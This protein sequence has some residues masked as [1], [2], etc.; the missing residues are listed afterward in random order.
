ML[1]K[2]MIFV[3]SLAGGGAERTIVNII[4]HINKKKYQVVLV[5]IK[6]VK[7]DH[8]KSKYLKLI[9]GECKII[10]LDTT[11]SKIYFFDIVFKLAKCIREEKPNILFSTI[12]KANIITFLGKVLSRY[13]V[14][15][16]L[17]ESNNRTAEG[18]SVIHKKA[19]SY[20]YNRA[21]KIISLSKGVA[22]DLINNFNINSKLINVIYNPID[23]KEIRR[24]SLQTKHLNLKSG[25][26]KLII[27]IGRLSE[28]KDFP[29]L[30][31]AFKIVSEDMNIKLLILGQGPLYGELYELTKE[32]KI[33]DKI[34]FLGFK[35]NP[36]PYIKQSDLFVLSSKFEG[37]GHVITES[38]A[39]DTP[40]I[41]SNCKSGPSEIIQDNISGDLFDVGNVNML[42]N[43]I[44]TLLED[45]NLKANYISAASRRVQD[46]EVESIIKEYENVF[47]QL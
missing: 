37:F 40:V 26:E 25:S 22:E 1:K 8:Q 15:I 7:K 43:K 27:S 46:F 21:S 13:K 9:E 47:D 41:S 6:N 2:L 39:L 10:Y 18:I 29:T 28:Q 20:I 4:K 30:I 16:V 11:L 5:M 23:I 38:M 44:L 33:E 31:K 14:P 35:E 17:R 32:L 42:A 45:D 34:T 19:V 12:Y 24:L 36:Y 3:P